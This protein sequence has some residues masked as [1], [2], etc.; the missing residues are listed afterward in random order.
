MSVRQAK[1]DE[2]NCV[3]G[4]GAVQIVW[5]TIL[6][7]ASQNRRENLPTLSAWLFSSGSRHMWRDIKLILK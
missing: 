7:P 1:T 6:P 3:A 2:T 4:C 5:L